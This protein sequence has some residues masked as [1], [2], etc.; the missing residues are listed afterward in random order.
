[1]DHAY[2]QPL[3]NGKIGEHPSVAVQYGEQLVNE[4]VIT[5]AELTQ[6]REAAKNR[7][8]TAFDKTQKEPERFH[9]PDLGAGAPR[10]S[11]GS[12]AVSRTDV[13]RVL[14]GLTDFPVS[15]HLHPK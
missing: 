5:N 13:E 6:M 15:F 14:A 12:T 1:D 9:V 8:V 4:G 11:R 3:V 10:R 7:Y 2:T